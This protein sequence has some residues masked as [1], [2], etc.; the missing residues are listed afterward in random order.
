[1]HL[2][3]AGRIVCGVPVRMF[4]GVPFRDK[5]PTCLPGEA[6]HAG[7]RAAW[8]RRARGGGCVSTIAITTPPADSSDT[9]RAGRM[10]HPLA[11]DIIKA[12]AEKHGVC[13]CPFMMEAATG[14]PARCCPT[15]DR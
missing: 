14:T 9:T 5:F 10:R 11:T 7:V 8:L 15:R 3:I 1:V 13:V 4:G 6:G 2:S 12:T